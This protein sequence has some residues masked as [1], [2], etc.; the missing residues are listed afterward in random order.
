MKTYDDWKTE[1]PE[2]L[3]NTCDYCGE[4]CAGGF[5]NKECEK[6]YITDNYYDDNE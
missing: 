6:A 2:E 5:C 1:Q 4:P 3:E